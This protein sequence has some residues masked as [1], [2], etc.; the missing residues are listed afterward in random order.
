MEKNEVVRSRL[1]YMSRT[2]LSILETVYFALATNRDLVKHPIYAN[3]TRRR[4]QTS[5]ITPS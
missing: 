5:T 3:M 2:S 1:I 4:S